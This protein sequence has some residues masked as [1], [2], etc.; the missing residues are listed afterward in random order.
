[1]EEFAYTSLGTKY[2]LID[3]EGKEKA[4]HMPMKILSSK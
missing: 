3:V 2:A 4:L 1:V